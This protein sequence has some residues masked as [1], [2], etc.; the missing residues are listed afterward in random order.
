MTP[1]ERLWAESQIGGHRQHPM[2]GQPRG[3]EV[4]DYK[5]YGELGVQLILEDGNGDLFE[6]VVSIPPAKRLASSKKLMVMRER[7]RERRK[8]EPTRR[9]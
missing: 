7:E 5:P 2:S 8:L 6:I 4:V 9:T 1:D 3:C